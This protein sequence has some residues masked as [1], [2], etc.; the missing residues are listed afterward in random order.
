MEKRRHPRADAYI[1]IGVRRLSL[2]KQTAYFSKISAAAASIGAE[3][4]AESDLEVNDVT[5]WLLDLQEKA[6]T[7]GRILDSA[8]KADGFHGLK[9]KQINLSGSGVRFLC[10]TRCNVNDLIELRMILPVEPPVPILIYGEV[11]RV[12]ESD[13]GYAA[14]A[15][16][17]A[18]SDEIRRDIAQFVN[19]LL[20]AT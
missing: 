16:F 14:A 7:M 9:Y 18:E 1:R 5:K 19:A 12:L 4:V 3:S 17:I 15:E 20:E 6:H 10:N 13:D 8:D 2:E 11:V